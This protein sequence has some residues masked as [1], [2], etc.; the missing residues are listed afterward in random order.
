MT[1]AHTPQTEY[2]VAPA[3]FQ[4][5]EA[6][7]RLIA[8]LEGRKRSGEILDYDLPALREKHWEIYTYI[9]REVFTHRDQR[10]ALR[11]ELY[12]LETLGLSLHVILQ[13]RTSNAEG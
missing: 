4:G 6:M 13:P 5:A 9:T 10:R 12:M 7:A 3:F 11:D 2:E 8:S 1:L